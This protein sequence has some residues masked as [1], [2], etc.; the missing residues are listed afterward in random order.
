MMGLEINKKVLY[1]AKCQPPTDE[2]LE[3]EFGGAFMGDSEIFKQVIDDKPT[4][5]LVMKNCVFARE[6]FTHEDYKELEFDIKDELV[7]YGDVKRCHLP[8]PPKY[9]D[10]HLLKG[11][12]KVFVRYANE[13]D[14]ENAKMKLFKRRFNDRYLEVNYYPEDKFINNIFE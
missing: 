10:P 13:K 3:L 1:V 6:D 11:F 8:R 14:A 4:S 7:K 12:G 5:C 2:E 9:G